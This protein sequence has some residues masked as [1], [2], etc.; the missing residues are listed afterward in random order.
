ML[1]GIG[2]EKRDNRRMPAIHLNPVFYNSTP[3][4]RISNTLDAYHAHLDACQWCLNHP[5]ALCGSGAELLAAVP[6]VRKPPKTQPGNE[7]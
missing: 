5:F 2:P 1:T 4:R 3:G 6:L 7:K